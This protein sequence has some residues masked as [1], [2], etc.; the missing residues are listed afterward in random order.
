M[1]P[2]T[3][4]PKAIIAAS[5]ALPLLLTACGSREPRAVAANNPSITYDYRGDRELLQANQNAMTYCNQYNALP[6]TV[7]VGEG[8][9]GRRVTFE[10]VP[11]NSIAE[12]QFAPDTPYRYR[13]DEELLTNS[14]SA[15]RYCRA[16][17]GETATSSIIEAPDG[18][19][20]VTYRC[21]MP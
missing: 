15:S 13:S 6:R 10:C 7:H 21:V 2:M 1:K 20:T 8:S 14:R 17:G 18:T 11:T 9:E 3:I 4:L 5:C 12:T 19:R 16:H